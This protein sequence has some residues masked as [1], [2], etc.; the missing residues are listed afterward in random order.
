MANEAPTAVP[1]VNELLGE[2]AGWRQATVYTVF[3]NVC[4]DGAVDRLRELAENEP[5]LRVVW[6]PENR[7]V[8]DA[9]VRGYREA[10][11]GGADWVLEIDA[12]YSHLPS[13]FT[14][15][16]E[17]VGSEVDCV[18]GSRFCQ[19][20]KLAD[21]PLKRRLLSRGGTALSNLLLNSRLTDMT[22]GYQLFRRE[23][24]Q[25]ILE[26]GIASRGHFFQ[27]EMKFHCRGLRCVEVPITYRSPSSSVSGETVG[28]ALRNLLKLARRR[29]E[30]PRTLR[31]ETAR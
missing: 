12:G 6:A 10:L 20:G 9:Y 8:V 11:S 22:S 2:T 21:A 26:E 17:K 14:R 16:Q 7:C 19:G 27:T 18:F 4:T 23:A 13:E 25:L 3:D 1:F 30:R 24:L 31:P 28:A 15:F 5:R 29:N